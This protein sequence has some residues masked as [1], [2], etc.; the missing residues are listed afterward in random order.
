MFELSVKNG[1]QLIVLENGNTHSISMDLNYWNVNDL[2]LHWAYETYGLLDGYS[3]K[4]LFTGMIAP[5]GQGYV[6]A[7]RT[8]RTR[9]Y[10]HFDDVLIQSPWR[11]HSYNPKDI[12]DY[13]SSSKYQIV[14]D[15]NFGL[16]GRIPEFTISIDELE[17]WH[18]GKLEASIPKDY[19]SKY[20]LSSNAPSI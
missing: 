2:L 13:L 16:D 14:Y 5:K 7:F 18:H 11:I 20:D 19:R 10:V 12:I 15:Y 8:V 17:K 3:L 4:F 1:N 6:R 9:D